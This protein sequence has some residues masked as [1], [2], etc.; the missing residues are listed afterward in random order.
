MGAGDESRHGYQKS[1]EG[2]VPPSV[3]PGVAT[4]TVTPRE[5][6][7]IL[8]EGD[9]R[10]EIAAKLGIGRPTVNG[11]IELIYRTLGVKNRVQAI[12]RGREYGLC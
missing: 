6:T 8:A 5:K 9:P 1:P 2:T 12:N 7:V 3:R 10:A 11:H 4:V